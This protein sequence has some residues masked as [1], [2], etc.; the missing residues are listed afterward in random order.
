MKKQAGLFLMA[1]VAATAPAIGEMARG[2]VFEDRNANGMQDEGE[3]GLAGVM[4]ST[5]DGS[6]VTT[7][8][9][10]TYEI[11]VDD[12]AIVFAIKPSGYMPPVDD[13]NLPQFFYIHK[14]EG[15]P[16]S[17]YDGVAPTGSL[18]EAINFPFVRQDESGPYRVV[19]MAD[20]QPE[21][22]Q[23]VTWVRDDV[24]AELP[25][26]GAAF[27]MS[28]GD[29]MF[30][31]LNLFEPYNQY[32]AA[33][34][35][36]F[37]NVIGN[38]DLNFDA[39]NDEYSDETFNRYFGPEYFAFHWGEAIFFVLDNIHW[40]GGKESTGNYTTMIEPEQTE[41]MARVLENVPEDKLVVVA[42]HAHLWSAGSR[43]PNIRNLDLLFEVLKDRPRVVAV[44]GHTH[45]TTNRFFGPEDGWTGEGTFQHNNITTVSGSWWSGPK[46]LRG[47]P[48]ATQRDGTPNGYHILEIDGNDYNIRYK[49]AGHDDDYQMR[50]YAPGQHSSG[51]NPGRTFLVNVFDGM[52]DA[53]VE[54]RINEGSFQPMTFAPQQ[55]PTA[56]ALYS[57]PLDSGKS[58]VNPTTAH[59]MWEATV[60]DD[61][62][63]G[64]HRIEVRY[65]D[66]LGRSYTAAD[67]F[68]R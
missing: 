41:W 13:Q 9:D 36:P 54:Y 24:L 21:T 17:F 25:E 29:I 63:R 16:G 27:G 31:H 51:E 45:I 40:D 7:G 52:P 43:N 26:I 60:A 19:L 68:T 64:T 55:D 62:P 66:R 20:T 47:I 53:T 33:V 34:G 4:V 61:L 58:W 18:P 38:H 14:P 5:T 3:P 30:D 46:D 6:V 15:S 59:H 2:T 37:Y 8:T 65:T 50:I 10:G 42:T 44:N 12:D 48:V 22:S 67:I 49:G 57:G 1:L 28:L 32:V 39:P 11:E 56:Q 23:E 35:I